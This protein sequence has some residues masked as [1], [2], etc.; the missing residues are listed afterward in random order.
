MASTGSV[1]SACDSHSGRWY[2]VSCECV[3]KS[4]IITFPHHLLQ[5]SLADPRI[6]PC[7]WTQRENDSLEIVSVTQKVNHLKPDISSFSKQRLVY[8]VVYP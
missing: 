1:L 5:I 4:T 2:I 3:N 7:C 8:N 6:Y